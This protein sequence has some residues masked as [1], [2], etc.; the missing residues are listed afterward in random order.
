MSM[1]VSGDTSKMA[2]RCVRHTQQTHV[3]D[4]DRLQTRGESP[5]ERPTTGRW[6]C[7]LKR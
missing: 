6:S 1:T 5:H 4:K 7:S 3:S 2:P